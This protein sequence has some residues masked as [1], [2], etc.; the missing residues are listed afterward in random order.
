M[1]NYRSQW[2]RI[3][4]TPYLTQSLGF[5]KQFYLHTEKLTGGFL[6]INDKSA[7]SLKVLKA[8]LSFGYHKRLNKHILHGGL[9]AGFVS[10]RW[11]PDQETFPNQFNWDNGA[12]DPSMPNNEGSATER[13]GYLD[14]NL[15]VGYNL[16]LKKLTPF[17]SYALYHVNYPKETLLG[18]KNNLKPRQVIN[19]GTGIAVTDNIN[20]EPNFLLMSTNRKKDVV[21]SEM[22]MGGNVHYKFSP[23]ASKASGMYA[24][25]FYRDG[26]KRNNDATFVTAGLK[27]K[28][29]LVGVS[30]DRNISNL[31]IATDHRGAF[32]LSFIYTSIDTRLKKVEIPC[33]RY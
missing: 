16:N 25:F 5:D 18:T 9:Q 24:G 28:N 12:Y 17:V 33:D 14:V 29:Y 8:L 15:G 10:K 22:V 26:L 30:Y 31:H 3:D 6:L 20:I 32:E 4:N 23:N 27:F 1:G 13:T 2:K 7:G 21:T 19:L 11:S